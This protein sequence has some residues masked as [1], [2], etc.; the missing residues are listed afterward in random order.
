[1]RVKCPVCKTSYEMNKSVNKKSASTIICAVCNNHLEI[2]PGT[3]KTLFL[4]KVLLR[5]K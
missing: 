4:P 1:M 2:L 5:A 3:W